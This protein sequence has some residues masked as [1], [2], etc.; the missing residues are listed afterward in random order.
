MLVTNKF[1]IGAYTDTKPT[2]PYPQQIA[3]AADLVG[4]SGWVMLYLCAWR[5]ESSSCMNASTLSIG[6]EDRAMLLAA[7]ARSLNVVVRLG[8]P[9][10]VRDHSDDVQHLRYTRLAAAY[11]HV[12]TSLP[13][14]PSG[15]QLYVHAGNEFNACNEWRCSSAPRQSEWSV[16]EPNISAVTMA[17]EVAGF[18]SDL[19][20]AVAPVLTPQLRYAH[21]PIADW[22]MAACAC[23]S[24]APLGQ[25][26]KGLQFLQAMLVAQPGLWQRRSISWFSSHSYPYSE[27]P[28]GD[29]DGKCMRGLTYYRNE[30]RLVAPAATLP[31]IVTET[32]WR[33]GARGSSPPFTADEQAN[34]TSL[35]FLRVWLPDPQVC[36]QSRLR[37]PCPSRPTCR[38][39]ALLPYPL[40]PDLIPFH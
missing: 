12:I 15:T 36:R 27:A 32:G 19:E 31:V 9:Y 22:N 5:S 11:A 28:W 14:P 38:S 6:A 37:L 24:G 25:G 23:P 39:I 34:W 4:Q 18:Y 29:P 20:R 8:Y 26:T 40:P 17:R 7:Y 1:G 33:T 13:Q 30:T 21:G 16:I 35:A 3:D 2:T 10:F